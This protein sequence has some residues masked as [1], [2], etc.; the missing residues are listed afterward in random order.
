MSTGVTVEQDENG[1]RTLS[2]FNRREVLLAGASVAAAAL[3]NGGRSTMAG[4]LATPI[5]AI[6]PNGDML[7]YRHEPPPLAWTG[8]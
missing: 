6:E 7:F 8:A 1:K 4:T 2:S 5:Y 3:L